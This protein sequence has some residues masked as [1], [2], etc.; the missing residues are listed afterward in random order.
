[1]TLQRFLQIFPRNYRI[2]V[3]GENGNKLFTGAIWWL[4]S[5]YLLSCLVVDVYIKNYLLYVVI[6]D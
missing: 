2:S 3:V 6:V 5:K 1:M 4:D